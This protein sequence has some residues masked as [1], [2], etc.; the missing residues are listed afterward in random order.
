MVLQTERLTV[1]H[2]SLDDAAFILQLLN[3]PSFLRYIGDRGVC[4][5]EDA[6]RYIETGPMESYQR[7]RFGLYGVALTGSGVLIGMCG[8][9]KR[10]ALPDPDI[11]FA[12][13]P[14][15]WSRG[16]AFEAATAVMAHSRDVLGIN[17]IVAIASPNNVSSIKLL[18]KLGL[19]FERL[20]QL[21]G[22]ESDVKYFVPAA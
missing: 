11:G 6:G 19:Q 20:M 13:L 16:Y 21:P 3:E 4:T 1:R 9:I 18:N 5:L 7:N 12:F 17:R 8:L 15:Y 2:L 10:P 22:S 14:A